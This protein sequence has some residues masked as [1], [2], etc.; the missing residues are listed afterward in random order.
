MLPEITVELAGRLGTWHPRHVREQ[1][2]TV[3]ATWLR[4][5]QHGL[6]GIYVL[7]KPGVRLAAA[8]PNREWVQL[9]GTLCPLRAQALPDDPRAADDVSSTPLLVH[10][11]SIRRARRSAH[12]PPLLPNAAALQVRA[13]VRTAAGQ[14]APAAHLPDLY[15]LTVDPAM[16]GQIRS[17]ST[18][19]GI[20]APIGRYRFLR[21]V[22]TEARP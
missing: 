4:T 15:H 9:R 2:Q 6:V 8:L 19:R 17:W 13:G 5:A 18:L 1:A 3:W 7:A 21:Y 20:V 12:A 14:L 10:A 22:V 11:V 16:P